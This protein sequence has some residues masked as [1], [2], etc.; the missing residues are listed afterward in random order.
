[1]PVVTPPETE[2]LRAAFA[3]FD[4]DGDGFMTLAELRTVLTRPGGGQPMA[5]EQIQK[6]FKKMDVDM[7]YGRWVFPGIEHRTERGGRVSWGPLGTAGDRSGPLG[8]A[9]VRSGPRGSCGNR[10]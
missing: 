6:L 3:K 2:K 10:Y 8:S 9:R 7:A 4:L 5:D 1:M